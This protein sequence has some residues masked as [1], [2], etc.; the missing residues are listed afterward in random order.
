M[1]GLPYPAGPAIAKLAEKGNPKAF[2]FPRPMLSSKDFDFSFSGLKTAVFREVTNQQPKTKDQKLI[3]D[4]CASVQQAIVDVLVT[5]TIRAAQKYN[6]KSILLC[7]GVAAND[8]LKKSLEMNSRLLSNRSQKLAVK[9]FV[10][11]KNLCTDNAAMI[12][13][14][15]FFHHKPVFW[16]KITANPELYF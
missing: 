5:K 8:V 16:Q 13:A 6:V 14:A 15:A 4:L 3:T 11:A 2:A 7:G 1:L 9:F 10:P 12:G